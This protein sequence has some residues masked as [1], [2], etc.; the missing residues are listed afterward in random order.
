MVAR[1]AANSQAKQG[2]EA[3]LWFDST[4]IQLFDPESGRSLLAGDRERERE[5]EAEREAHAPAGA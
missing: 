4:Q 3:E 2:Q 5:A 1:F